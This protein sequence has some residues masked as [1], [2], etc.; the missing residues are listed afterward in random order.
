MLLQHFPWDLSKIPSPPPPKPLCSTSPI[1]IPQAIFLYF[2][3]SPSHTSI[4]QCSLSQPSLE[5]TQ[6]SLPQAVLLSTILVSLPEKRGERVCVGTKR[7]RSPLQREKASAPIAIT[8]SVSLNIIFYF[9]LFFFANTMY[10]RDLDLSLHQGREGS[11]QQS[12]IE[13]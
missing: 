6:P 11:I 7:K 4:S 8:N 3:A 13:L 1:H 10:L 2:T 5:T 9:L 12:C